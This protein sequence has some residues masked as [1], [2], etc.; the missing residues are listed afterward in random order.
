MYIYCHLPNLEH[1]NQRTVY[2]FF[3]RSNNSWKLIS[4]VNWI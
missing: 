2:I 3:T 4:Q 1:M